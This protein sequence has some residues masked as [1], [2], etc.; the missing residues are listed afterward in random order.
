MI[1][2]DPADYRDLVR[3][4]VAEDVG[5]GDLTSRLVVPAGARAKGQI[6]AKQSCVIAG[7]PIATAVFAEVDEAIHCEALVNDGQRVESDAVIAEIDGPAASILAAERVALNFLQHLSGIA[8]LT[9]RFV[10]A[11]G[12]RIDVLDTRKTIPTWRPLAKYAVRCGGGRNHRMGLYDAILIKDN[13]IRL[14]G[15]IGPAVALARAGAGSIPV[16]VETETLA[17]VDAALAAGADIIMLDNFD[18]PG[19]RGAVARIAGRAQIEVSGGVTLDRM[20]GLAALGVNFVSVGALTHSAPA[21]D[22]S[23]ELDTGAGS[24]SR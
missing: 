12:G 3:R 23:L 6:I 9:R 17:D 2:L 13:H 5:P 11:A 19:V 8:T 4:A 21:A 1:P 22:L 15:G 16:E 24:G 20:P 14:A 7:L 18:D 10:N